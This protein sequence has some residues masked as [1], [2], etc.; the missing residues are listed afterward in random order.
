MAGSGDGGGGGNQGQEGVTWSAIGYPEAEPC[1]DCRRRCDPINRDS[2]PMAAATALNPFLPPV[3]F[4]A[5]A[6]WWIAT[7]YCV[8]LCERH[9]NVPVELRRWYNLLVLLTG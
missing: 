3:G 5:F 6:A 2:P 4:A 9:P 7:L 8:A 1:T